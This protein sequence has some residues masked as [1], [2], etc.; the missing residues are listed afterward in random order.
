MRAPSEVDASK[1]ENPAQ[2][3]ATH[4][5]CTASSQRAFIGLLANSRWSDARL[6]STVSLHKSFEL[7][8]FEFLRRTGQLHPSK[9]TISPYSARTYVD[10]LNTPYAL[11]NPPPTGKPFHP[12]RP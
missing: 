2:A 10:T 8:K 12:W 1:L 6:T 9:R 11:P 3:K 7:N 4:R 5:S